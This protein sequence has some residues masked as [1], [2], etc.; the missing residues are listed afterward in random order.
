MRA[1]VTGAS[2][3]VGTWLTRHLEEVGDAAFALGEGID[4]TD[5]PAVA[6]SIAAASPDVIYHLAA[7]THVGDSWEAPEE[8]FRVNAMGT[9]SVLEAA[10]KAQRTPRIILVSSAEVYG[11]G[12]QVPIDETMPLRPVTP[13]AASKVAAEYLGLQ[14]HLGRGIEVVRARPFNHVGPGQS[15]NFVIAALAKRLVEAERAGALEVSVGDLSPARDFTDVRDVVRAYRLLAEYGEPGEAYNVCSGEAV[16]IATVFEELV[17]LS[18]HQVKAVVDPALLR[19]V[20]VPVLV[21][22]AKRLVSLTGWSRT[23]PLETTLKDVL[24][25]ARSR[26]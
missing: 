6:A 9:L 15:P 7:L 18:D 26:W 12:E 19:P 17:M 20:D 3:F 10:R 11:P 21:G 13:Y 16:A 4:V 22:E 8:T 23:I 25:D 1:F 2:G 24:A 14:A 5:T